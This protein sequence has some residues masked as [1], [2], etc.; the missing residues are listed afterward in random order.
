MNIKFALNTLYYGDMTVLRIF[1][2]SLEK[3]WL[4]L[5]LSMVPIAPRYF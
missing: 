3:I 5:T 2:A 4:Y 1:N